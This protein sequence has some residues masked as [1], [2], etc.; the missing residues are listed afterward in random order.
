MP[1]ADK[2]ELVPFEIEVTV[3]R[4]KVT[5]ELMLRPGTVVE[6]Q[7]GPTVSVETTPEPSVPSSR[8]VEDEARAYCDQ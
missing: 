5:V 2:S 6:Q 4:V 3:G 8:S 7:S 1:D